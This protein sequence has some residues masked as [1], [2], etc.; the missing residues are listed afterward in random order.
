MLS[1]FFYFVYLSYTCLFLVIVVKNIF[2]HSNL[3]L[4]RSWYDTFTMKSQLQVSSSFS[5]IPT[6]FDSKGNIKF[7]KSIMM[8]MSK[9]VLYFMNIIV[10]IYDLYTH[11]HVYT[12][13][14]IK[15]F[16][17]T[18]IFWVSQYRYFRLSLLN[19]CLLFILYQQQRFPRSNS[20]CT[21]SFVL[22]VVC[23]KMCNKI[24]KFIHYIQTILNYQE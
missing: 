20:V 11:T 15:H 17:F 18:H 21:L 2:I 8:M 5:S 19:F 24:I 6:N 9:H 22:F 4:F 10:N 13:G 12:H 7:D 1:H 23:S 14:I 3:L 16:P